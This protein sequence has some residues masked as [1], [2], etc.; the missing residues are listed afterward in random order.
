[1]RDIRNKLD[2]KVKSNKKRR[3]KRGKKSALKKFGTE[4]EVD[5]G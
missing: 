1:L 5:D 3:K 4:S 2:E